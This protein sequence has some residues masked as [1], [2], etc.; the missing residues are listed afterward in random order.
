MMTVLPFAKPF[1]SMQNTDFVKIIAFLILVAVLLYYK[2]PGLIAGMLDKRAERIRAE[3]DEA[4]ALREEAQTLLASFER[5]QKEV[6]GQ[7]EAIITAA[8]AEAETAAEQAKEDL[9]ETIAR[10]L[11]AATDQIASVEQ[12]AVREVRDRAVTVAVAAAAEVLA[13]KMDAGKS[14]ALID[15][16]IGQVGDKLH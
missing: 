3:I 13:A 9:K 15:D 1:F 16:A 11:A 8:K 7:A 12:A 10:R 6:A 4:R 5:K 14:D 2:V